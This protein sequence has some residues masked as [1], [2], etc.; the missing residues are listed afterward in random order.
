MRYG[1]YSA[2]RTDKLAGLLYNLNVLQKQNCVFC[3]HR[4]VIA[5][6]IILYTLKQM[7]AAVYDFESRTSLSQC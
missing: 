1:Q 6:W 2:Y 5:Y 4:P 3:Q 7:Q